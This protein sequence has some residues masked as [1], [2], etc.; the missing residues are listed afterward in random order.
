MA[1]FIVSFLVGIV[2]VAL[3]ISNTRG[4]ISSLHSY[5]RNRVAPEDVLPFGKKVG[6]GTIII[7]CAIM[8]FSVLSAVALYTENQLFTLVGT[9]VMIIGLV[10]GM[11]IAFHAMIKYNKGIF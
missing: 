10:V 3:G 7:G 6:L 4:N 2:C 8:I 9:A 1:G 11:I 5:H